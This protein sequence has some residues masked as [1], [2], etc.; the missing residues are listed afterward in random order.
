LERS[1]NTELA[2]RPCTLPL[3]TYR[4][5]STLA[6]L[7]KIENTEPARPRTHLAPDDNWHPCDEAVSSNSAN[8]LDGLKAP[9]HPNLPALG[10][11]LHKTRSATVN[12]K[13]NGTCA[14]K[15][16][17]RIGCSAADLQASQPCRMLV[18]GPLGSEIHRGGM[19]CNS[20]YCCRYFTFCKKKG[21]TL[22]AYHYF[23]FQECKLII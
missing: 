17:Y 1:L 22:C 3:A 8:T 10:E 2:P 11:M 16:T 18:L 9:K 13:G 7:G 23:Y 19:L 15:Y 21:T 14:F 6:G 20:Q 12:Y 4:K 5:F